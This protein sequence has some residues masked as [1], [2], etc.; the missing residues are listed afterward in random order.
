M[1]QE[2]KKME[3]ETQMIINLKNTEL[4]KLKEEILNLQQTKLVTVNTDVTFHKTPNIEPVK[5][6]KRVSKSTQVTREMQKLDDEWKDCK[7]GNHD[8]D[9]QAQKGGTSEDPELLSTFN[10]TREL[11]RNETTEMDEVDRPSKKPD[12]DIVKTKKCYR[13]RD[14]K[15]LRR[16]CTV[17]LKTWSKY[18]RMQPCHICKENRALSNK[19]LVQ[20]SKTW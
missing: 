16:D 3:H 15:H 4:L 8:P 7:N 19:L 12:H 6:K 13:C 9:Q 2:W 1:K 18:S 11:T 17:G 20:G 10:Y 5:S 14:D